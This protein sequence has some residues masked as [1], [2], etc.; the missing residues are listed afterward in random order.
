[1]LRLGRTFG[2]GIVVIF[3]VI[4]LIASVQQLRGQSATPMAGFA[5]THVGIIVYYQSK[6][7]SWLTVLRQ[8]GDG[9]R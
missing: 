5:V 4:G 2:R 8:H 7:K 3:A 6:N 9:E 1:M